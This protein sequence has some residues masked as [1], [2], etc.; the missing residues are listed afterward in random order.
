MISAF[1]PV[2]ERGLHPELVLSPQPHRLVGGLHE[3]G[4]AVRVAGVVVVMHSEP[5]HP[6]SEGILQ[7]GHVGQEQQ[8]PGRDVRRGHPALPSPDLVLREAAA[9]LS[10]SAEPRMGGSSTR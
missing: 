1:G 4:T 10:V 3:L 6:R 7:A 5:Q 9:S 8:V 2:D